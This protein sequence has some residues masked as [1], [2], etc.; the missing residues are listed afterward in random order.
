MPERNTYTAYY[1]KIPLNFWFYFWLGM[2]A[3][4]VV[5]VIIRVMSLLSGENN[6]SEGWVGPAVNS[7]IAYSVIERCYKQY[8]NSKINNC[9]I[10]ID[11]EGIKWRL[12]EA[13]YKVREKEIIV[14]Q[15]IKKVIIN[16][17][18]ITIKYMST[19]FTDTIPYATISAE[20]KGQLLTALRVQLND[21]SIVSEDRLAA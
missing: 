20:D 3:I 6:N 7:F 12:P 16:E 17:N 9:F 2:S 8:R 11:E 21:R 19:Y 4:A 1:Q 5:L 14:W 10:T 13:N 18:G 15:D